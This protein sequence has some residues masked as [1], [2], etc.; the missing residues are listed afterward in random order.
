[1]QNC[2]YEHKI[3][4]TECILATRLLACIYNKS[5]CRYIFKKNWSEYLELQIPMEGHNHNAR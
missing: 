2:I 5:K 3:L 1:M 4:I